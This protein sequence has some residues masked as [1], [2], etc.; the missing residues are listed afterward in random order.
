[1][2]PIRRYQLAC[3]VLAASTLAALAWPRPGAPAAGGAARPAARGHAAA[4]DLRRPL[5]VSAAAVGLSERE[6]IDALRAAR[7]L[8]EVQIYADKLGLSC[9]DAR[10]FRI[11]GKA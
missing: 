10:R 11:D 8:P 7:T 6:L 1:M 3:A 4:Q 2:T 9:R 5:R